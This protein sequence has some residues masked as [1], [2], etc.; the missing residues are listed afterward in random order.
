MPIIA[1]LL[2]A[3][4]DGCDAFP[5]IGKNETLSG[6]WQSDDQRSEIR[7]QS[8]ADYY[9][10][11]LNSSKNIRIFLQSSV[12]TYLYLREG[13]DP[14]GLVVFK[15]DDIDSSNLNSLIET[16][17]LQG[18]YLIEAT[19]FFSGVVGDYMLRTSTID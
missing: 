7:P 11:T 16:N 13:C 1:L 3:E 8:P 17:N 14:G 12:D 19:T 2:L 10:L 15:N 6:S 18:K 4:D 5:Q 9:V